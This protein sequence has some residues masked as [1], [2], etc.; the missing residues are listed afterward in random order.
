[1]TSLQL[2]STFD[3][4]FSLIIFKNKI[5]NIQPY[6]VEN[7]YKNFGFDDAK[8]VEN[9]K[10]GIYDKIL[11]YDTEYYI[12]W[13]FVDD[14]NIA[15]LKLSLSDS[16]K[17]ILDKRL[18]NKLYIQV[19]CSSCKIN[20]AFQSSD[21]QLTEIN[22]PVNISFDQETDDTLNVY[23]VTKSQK[24]ISG[25]LAMI[26]KKEKICGRIKLIIVVDVDNNVPN[27]DAI[28]ALNLLNEYYK[29]ANIHFEAATNL[30][31]TIHL[32]DSVILNCSSAQKYYKSFDPE[33]YHLF[34]CNQNNGN[35]NG[36]GLPPS[37]NRNY[38][39]AYVNFSDNYV[40][41]VHEIG[42]CLGLPHT[43]ESK[44]T[45]QMNYMESVKIK[46]YSTKNIM[47]YFEN[48]DNRK[49]LFKNQMMF[50][51]NKKDK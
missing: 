38:G 35:N 7:Y 32:K 30:L 6:N 31:D 46:K 1:M 44:D 13:L 4:S 37:K 5:V 20:G 27:I 48:E 41:L 17:L 42:H 47:D 10:A 36:A 33:T 16:Q 51:Y 3:H 34:I 50:I 49:Y 43:F 2:D 12:P 9:Q 25:K 21:I 8:N 14:I 26:C 29:Q 15:D 40:T 11:M 28:K 19:Q 24:E 45:N 39:I 22:K 23:L 18:K